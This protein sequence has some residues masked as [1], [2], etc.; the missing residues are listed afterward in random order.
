MLTQILVFLTLSIE[1]RLAYHI[2]KDTSGDPM[3]SGGY[4]LATL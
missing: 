4:Q 1:F 3:E 2:E